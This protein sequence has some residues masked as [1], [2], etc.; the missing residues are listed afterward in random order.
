[1]DLSQQRVE[2]AQNTALLIQT[3][4]YLEYSLWARSE[5]GVGGYSK[6]EGTISAQSDPAQPSSLMKS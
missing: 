4:I 6:I 3:L 5:L 2:W 1:M